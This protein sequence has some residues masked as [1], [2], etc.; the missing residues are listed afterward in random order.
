[1]KRA[2]LAG[3]I[4]A[5]ALGMTTPAFGDAERPAALQGVGI[6]QRLD[7]QLPLDL[8][9][10]DERG[11]TVKLADFFADKPV[12]LDFAYYRCP[13]LCPM[14]LDALVRTMRPLTMSVGE[15]FDIVTVSIDSRETP[16]A[17]AEK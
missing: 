10:R 15:E 3:A 9:F 16:A 5:T 4:A 14:A 7:Q 11:E 6:E 8:A 13:M 12:L 1:M 17:A 2:I